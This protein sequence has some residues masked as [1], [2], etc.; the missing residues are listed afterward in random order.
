MKILQ[1]VYTIAASVALI[2]SATA[3]SAQGNVDQVQTQISGGMTEDWKPSLK[4]DGVYDRVEHV[5]APLE[6]QYVRE[7]DILWKKRV[8]REIDAREKQNMAFRFPGDEN[9]GGGFFIEILLDALKK[10]KIQAFSNLDDRFT[11]TLSKEQIVE[12][13]QGRLDTFEIVDPVTD[14]ITIKIERREF[15]PE[16]VNKFRIK[17]DWIIDRNV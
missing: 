7:A 13:T 16:S 2:C 5:N 6:W 11:S 12:I 17:E 3:V 9:S 8:W 4:R 14:E 1:Q 10:G 15:N